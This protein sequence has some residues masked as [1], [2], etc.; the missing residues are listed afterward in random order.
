MLNKEKLTKSRIEWIDIAKGIA[1]VCIVVGHIIVLIP[2]FSVLFQIIYLFHVPL[3][4]FISG[5]LFKKESNQIK[6]VIKKVRHLIIPYF[7]V[8]LLIAPIILY[9]ESASISDF[10]V[11][12]KKYIWGGEQLEVIL[13]G[14]FIPMWFL[15]A[16]FITQIIY[17]GL[18]NCFKIKVMH[19][20]ALVLYIVNIF[21]VLYFKGFSLPWSVH[22]ITLSIPIF[23]IGY[24]FKNIDMPKR[25]FV[26]PCFLALLSPILI[27]GNTMDMSKANSGIPVLTLISSI[28]AILAVIYVSKKVS[29][30]K[31]AKLFVQ[32]GKASL[33]I[34]AFHFPVYISFYHSGYINLNSD[35]IGLVVAFWTVIVT[36]ICYGIYFIFD[37]FVITRILFLG[38]N[39]LN[40]K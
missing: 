2:Q 5:F 23:H 4:F 9:I 24:I 26:I 30:T 35:Y 6:Y 15:P 22:V 3:F 18:Q 21:Q 29:G 28:L 27:S 39:N 33:V 13:R 38:E 11:A 37:K 20:I 19:T 12:C 34:M 32:L 25:I 1:I 7:C 8:F 40:K 10:F 17:N 16:L 31:I 36:S 14:A